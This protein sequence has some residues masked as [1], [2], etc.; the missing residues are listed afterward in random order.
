MTWNLAETMNR[1]G[2]LVNLAS[3]DGLRY[4]QAEHLLRGE[5]PFEHI[6]HHSEPD[7]MAGH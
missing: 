7:S 5:V 2:K 1:L 3:T 6:R 4:H